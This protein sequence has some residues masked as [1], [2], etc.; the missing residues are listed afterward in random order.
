M[1]DTLNNLAKVFKD[2]GYATGA[3]GKWGL[4]PP[5]SIGDP[6][7][8]GFDR[9][10]GYNCQRFGH[11]YYP[12]H[13]W[14]NADSVVLE[15]NR[16]NQNGAYAPQLIQEQLLNFIE[17]N[18]DRPFFLF[19]PTIIPHAELVAPEEYMNR[20]RGK[21]GNEKPYEGVDEGAQLRQGPYQSQS[22]P[23]AAFAAMMTLLDDQV[24]E[25]VKKVEELG[26]AENTLIIFTSDNGPHL[27]G[28]ADP[29]FFDSNGPLSGYKRDLYEGG[30]R[31]PMIAYWP[32]R[33]KPGETGHV[34]AFWDVMPTMEEL[35]G[36]PVSEG[37]GVS[38]LPTLLGEGVQ[39]DHDYLYWEFHEKGGRQAVRK[40][41]YKAVRYNVFDHP[42][43]PPELY[44]LST[45]LSEQNNI[46]K[47]HPN[48]V[49][50][51]DSIMQ[52]A[53][54]PSPVFKFGDETYLAQ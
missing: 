28:G 32:D 21:F 45:D 41:D 50:L 5:G 37:D 38:F 13:L 51:M 10:Y 36:Q 1:P 8:Q 12:Y 19:M 46:A 42:D 23:R 2:A 29:D 15:S 44:D 3:F 26:L 6:L 31:V 49:Q 47:D 35:M 25:I 24:G 54:V 18:K 4:G 17:G 7:N 40:G 20:F 27:E 30:I 16:G 48:I 34:S 22:E 33:I 43:S 39:L 14:S 9:F 52:A 53:R 11:N